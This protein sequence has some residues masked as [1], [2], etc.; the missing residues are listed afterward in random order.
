ML[1]LIFYFGLI[2]SVVCAHFNNKT[3]QDDDALDINTT[4]STYTSTTISVSKDCVL[5][6]RED[7]ISQIVEL[8]NSNIVNVVDI[9]ISFSKTNHDKQFL[10]DFYISL[11]KP[12]G[13]EILYALERWQFK[14]VAWTLKVGI[15][16][17]KFNVKGSQ[18][19]CINKTGMSATDF[20]FDTTQYIVDRINL[21]TNYHLC[22]SFKET[23]SGKV[24][25]T[26]CQMMKPYLGTKF[27]YKCPKGSSFLF[28]SESLWIGIYFMMYVL[29]HFYFLWLLSALLARTEFNLKYPEYYKLEESLLSL[30]S[31]LLKVIWDENGR[32]A[33]FL[34]RLVSVCVVSYFCYLMSISI[35]EQTIASAILTSFFVFLGL[36]FLV[37]NLFTSRITNSSIILDKMKEHNVLRNEFCRHYIGPLSES[38]IRG[39]FEIIVKIII[40]PVNPNFWGNIIKML[41]N[42]CAAFA[43]YVTGKFS[44]RTLKTLALCS[45]SVFAVSICFV[46]VSIRFCSLLVFATTFPLFLECL[47]LY[48]TYVLEYREDN[49]SNKI[50]SF[51]HPCSLSFSFF[52]SVAIT[53]LSVVSFLLGLFLNLFYFIPYFAFFSVLTFYCCT[54]WKTMEE[55]YFVLKQLIYEACRETQ[56]KNDGSI[57]N[58]L[59]PNQEVL[60]VVSKA[61][62]DKIREKL[63]PYDTNLF[64]FGLKMFWSIAFSLAILALINMLNE[65]NVAG[66]VQVVTTASLGVVPHIF[67]IISSKTSEAKIEARNENL[68]LNVNYMVDKLISEDPQLA[69]TVLII[70]HNDDA[71]VNNFSV[72]E[73]NIQ[74]ESSV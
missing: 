48:L 16:N 23:S 34:R 46:Y 74:Y 37:F 2:P 52:I 55:K 71:T 36:S 25:Q 49:F 40:F 67:N 38:G 13:Q 5:E 24:N 66:L 61:L 15:T 42:N 58:R 44:S 65:F 50:L 59:E 45:Y 39:D 28:G 41:Y 1:V 29:A 53:T 35:T 22:S 73:E 18:N 14:F 64:Y 43:R 30:S 63:L 51:F 19:D 4:L 72:V 47:L 21:A 6:I 62:Y 57:P 11:S 12:T 3:L 10:M 70:E 33:S 31:I 26:C 17:F 68:K 69:R 54:Y 32:V 7:E 27:N 20:A 60:P 56:N 9:H 8:F